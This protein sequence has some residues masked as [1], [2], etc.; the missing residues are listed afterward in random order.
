MDEEPYFDGTFWLDLRVAEKRFQFLSLPASE[1]Y[2][3]SNVVDQRRKRCDE[4][5]AAVAVTC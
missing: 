5:L 1:D 2:Q 4:Q 3:T